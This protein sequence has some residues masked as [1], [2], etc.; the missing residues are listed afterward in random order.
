[1]AD[2]AG[3]YRVGS[4]TIGFAT[5]GVKRVAIDS[6]LRLYGVARMIAVGDGSSGAPD[7]TFASALST[8]MYPVASDTLGLVGGGVTS[9]YISDSYVRSL[10]EHRFVSGNADD[11]GINWADDTNSGFYWNDFM[12]VARNGTAVA[13]WNPA[14]S[15]A[16]SSITIMTR[17]KGD[18]RYDLSS[19]LRF[20]ENVGA[21]PAAVLKAKLLAAFDKFDITSWIWGGEISDED[22]RYGDPGIGMIAENVLEYLPEAVKHQWVEE[23]KTKRPNA[24]DPFPIISSLIEKIRQ[25][26]ERLVAVGG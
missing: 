12:Y 17:E 5:A 4:N 13:R 25:L 20:K 14:G 21:T 10:R 15:T 19:S 16:N 22:E 23:G 8:G 9:M 18:S 26:E 3:M 1:L 7:Y 2:A 24:L 6:H 11:P